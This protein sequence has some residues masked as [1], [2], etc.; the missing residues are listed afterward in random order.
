MNSVLR[1]VATDGTLVTFSYK[2]HELSVKVVLTLIDL[3]ALRTL[4]LCNALPIRNNLSVSLSL[5][6]V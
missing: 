5:A 4:Y 2:I 6:L 3:L 1:N